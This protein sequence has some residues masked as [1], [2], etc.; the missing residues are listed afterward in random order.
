MSANSD[1]D[2]LNLS[3]DLGVCPQETVADLE[4][5]AKAHLGEMP[6]CQ[7]QRRPLLPEE[8]Q[9]VNRSS[10]RCFSHGG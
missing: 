6:V 1:L 3:L 10:G 5:K 2:L 8:R 7:H 4:H 9:S